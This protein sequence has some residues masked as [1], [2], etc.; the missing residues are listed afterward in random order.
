MTDVNS[1]EL[2]R[3]TDLDAQMVLA[4]KEIKVLSNLTWPADLFPQFIESWQRGSPTL[5]Q[6][7]FPKFDFS[8]QLAQLHRIMGDCDH[9]HPVGRYIY[10]TAHSYTQ[11]ATMLENI[12]NPVFCEMSKELYGVP[13]DS[14]G[15]SN[16]TNLSA[17]EHFIR[18]IDDFSDFL[19]TPEPAHCLTPESVADELRLIFSGV[20]QRHPVDVVIDKRLASKAAA[21]ARR[22]RIRGG[23]NFSPLDIQQLAQHEGFVHSAT[24]LNGREQPALK[25]MGLGSPRTTSTQ[26]G[27]ATFAEFI[28]AT[29]DVNRL[30]RIALRIKAIHLAL[31]G[32]DFCDVFRF[33]LESGQSEEESF[34]SSARVFR[35]GNVRGRFVFTK[36]VVYLQGLMFVHTFMRKAI[37]ANKILYPTYL[38]VGRLTLGDVVALEDFIKSGYIAMPLYKAPWLGNSECLAAYLCY[39]SFANRINLSQITLED[40]VEFDR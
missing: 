26:E 25:S 1:S 38:F 2:Q 31:E 3:Y 16:V 6:P 17:A 24:M 9:S 39:A 21:G 36:D 27:L 29:M 8:G 33:F 13:E 37:Q 34:Q 7:T 19:H 35:G 20:F 4:A 10:Q 11:A 12:G 30:K 5:P 15:S 40:F 23:T 32:A 18:T 22:V 14:M 28:T